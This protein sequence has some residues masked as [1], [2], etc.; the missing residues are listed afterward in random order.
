MRKKRGGDVLAKVSEMFDLPGE[1]GMGVPRVTVTG[2]HQVHVENHRGL[3]EYGPETI[4]ANCAGLM[5]KIRGAKL[6]ISAM[7]DLELVVTGVVS[8]VELIS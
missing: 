6:E 2:S 8:G 5:V 3:L 7:S 4:V 1:V